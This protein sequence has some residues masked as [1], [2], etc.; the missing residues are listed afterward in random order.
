MKPWI[1]SAID[2]QINLRAIAAREPRNPI[3]AAGEAPDRRSPLAYL[4]DSL[5]VIAKLG[6]TLLHIMP[7]FLIGEKERK[8]IG[9]PYAVRDYRRIDPEFGSEHELAEV[10]R[11]AHDLG[12]HVILGVVPNHTSPDNVW[13]TSNPEFYVQNDQ[14]RIVY[15]LDWSDTAK[16]NYHAPGLRKAMLEVCDYWLGFL[17]RNAA[18]FA[19]GVD[20]FRFDMAH[21]INDVSFWSEALPE[22]RRR[23]SDR[24]LLFLAECYGMD[25]NLD[26]FRRDMN[27]AYDDDLYK[28]CEAF[29]GVDGDGNSRLLPPEEAHRH[30][31]FGWSREQLA[32]AG[33]AGVVEKLMGLYE[34]ALPQMPGKPRLARYTDNHDE[35]RGAYRFGEGATR[36]FNLLIHCSPNTIPF[37]LCG[38]EFGALNR[39][40][41]HDRLKP[42]D[43]GRKV[44]RGDQIHR[45]D[46]V[47]I[48]GNVFARGAQARR[49][50]YDYFRALMAL[51]L[52]TPELL[53]GSYA[54]LPADLTGQTGGRTVTAFE[55]AHE[56]SRVRCAINLGPEPV[57]ILRTDLLKGRALF[58]ALD[59]DRL[60]GFGG[61]V[62]R[63]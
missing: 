37:L 28:V 29:Y 4:R 53:H 10:V 17:G 19:D 15:D 36:A 63:V 16:L 52:S 14:G 51:R 40:S 59:G 48:E 30:R 55:R 45:Q 21:F 46:G 31:D 32:A 23:H 11:G 3:E 34:Q 26:L 38:A 49:E 8:G 7:P 6:V 43:K 41:I 61:L 5:H 12:M 27:A 24:E 39:P 50:W 13:V 2:Y 22:L 42:C 9:S 1:A 57:R 35:G 62:V 25:N 18:G 47:E 44:V 20:G 60:P 58:G 33:I 54:L 56:G